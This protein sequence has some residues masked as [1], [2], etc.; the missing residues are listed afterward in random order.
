MEKPGQ[1]GGLRREAGALWIVRG[2][3]L[4]RGGGGWVSESAAQCRPS[5][6]VCE[7]GG[8]GGW[9]AGLLPSLPHDAFW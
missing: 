8:V 4:D 3:V 9:R 7:L 6:S 5:L 2:D 1:G